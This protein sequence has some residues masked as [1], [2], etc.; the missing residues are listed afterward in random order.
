MILSLKLMFTI[1]LHAYIVPIH[2]TRPHSSSRNARGGSRG[3]WEGKR[4]EDFLPRFPPF[5]HTPRATK[6]RQGERRLEQVRLYMESRRKLGQRNVDYESKLSG[7]LNYSS[8]HSIWK[9]TCPK[10]STFFTNCKHKSKKN[11]TQKTAYIFAPSQLSLNS[12]LRN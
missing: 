1:I 5:H 10:R 8:I 4:E 2:L 11:C 7:L 12:P 6:E 3:W 9:G